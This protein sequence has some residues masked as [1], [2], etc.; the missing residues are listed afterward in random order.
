MLINL[1]RHPGRRSLSASSRIRELLKLV[2]AALHAARVNLN[3]EGGDIHGQAA[4]DPAGAFIERSLTAS[5][6][7]ARNRPGEVSC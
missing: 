4:L 6:A 5:V 7:A 1:A 2:V 3:A